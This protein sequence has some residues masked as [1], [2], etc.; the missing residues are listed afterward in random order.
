MN[1]GSNALSESRLESQVGASAAVLRSRPMLWSVR[2]ELWENRSVYIA[3]LATGALVVFGFLVATWGRAL[4]TPDHARR[5][6]ILTE[7]NSF[8]AGV[9][10]AVAFVV[11][12]LYCLDALYGERR[13][14]SILF[15]KSLPV[16]DLTVVLS[17]AFVAIV[18][19]PLLTATIIIAT[20][21][22][23][24][25]LSA[26]VLA[27]SGMSVG[28]LWS[29]EFQVSVGMLYHLI[30]VHSLWHAPIYAWLLLVSAWARR[31]PFLWAVLPPVAIG[32][33]EKLAFNST[34]FANLMGYRFGG[35]EHYDLGASGSMPLSHLSHFELGRFLITPGLWTGLL[36]AA[37]FLAVAVQV[38]RYR[39]PV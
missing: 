23:M 39:G 35:P 2:R 16:S 13:D 15:W 27:G 1:P 18:F 11:G 17:K 12:I 37:A 33:V 7:S 22:I 38:R 14:R 32:V 19:L 26:M 34:H 8:A 5:A 21:I 9:I 36:V 28:A 31:V 10:M 6:A 29:Q 4:A 24:T 25:L 30:T 20:Q 3:P